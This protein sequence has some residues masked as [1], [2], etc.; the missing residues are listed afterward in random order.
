MSGVLGEL[1]VRVAVA[2]AVYE[3]VVSRPS[4]SKRYALEALRIKRLF[5][6]GVISK[7]SADGRVTDR[8]LSLANSVFE[9]KGRPLSIIHSGEAEALSLIKTLSADALLIDERTTRLLIEDPSSLSGFLSERSNAKV[10]MNERRFRELSV[11]IPKVPVL[12]S[13]E[14]AALAYEAG[15]LPKMLN[16][17]GKKVLDASL[18]ALK[19]SGCA[20]TW[21][22]IDEYLRIIP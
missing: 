18:S 7:V 3:E 15:V 22:E 11:Y 5:T 20:I 10:R 21:E 1:N 13:T 2:P 16:A 17:S 4:E 9:V 12:R 6:D 14:I 19:Y 8:I